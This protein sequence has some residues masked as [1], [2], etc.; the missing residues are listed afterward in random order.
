MAKKFELSTDKKKLQESVKNTS[1]SINNE[2]K[3]LKAIIRMMKEGSEKNNDYHT[4]LCVLFGVNA[5]V[6][7]N[8][9]TNEKGKKLLKANYPFVNG[10]GVMLRRVRVRYGDTF[11]ESVIGY[12]WTPITDYL[13]AITDTCNNIIKKGTQR[14]ID[15]ESIT[16]KNGTP[17][18][19]KVADA[20]IWKADGTM[21]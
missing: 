7:V 6:D 13:K 2:R 20:T 4:T 16:D 8:T 19:M 1:K 11:A 3:G 12:T 9:L 14:I 18:G 10:E 21:K 17:V 5:D 15:I